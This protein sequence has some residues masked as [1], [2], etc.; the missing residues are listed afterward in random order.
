VRISNLEV[1]SRQLNVAVRFFL[2]GD[3]LSSLTLAGAAEEILGVLSR[4][5]GNT[6][7][8]ESIIRFH[9]QDTDPNMGKSDKLDDRSYATAAASLPTRTDRPLEMHKIFKTQPF[10][11]AC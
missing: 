1:A 6:N 8:V 4:R 2:D 5:A 11:A 7:A 3:Y 10:S 9:W